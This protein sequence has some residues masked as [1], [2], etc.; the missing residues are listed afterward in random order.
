MIYHNTRERATTVNL[1]AE[2]KAF[3]P[4]IDQLRI[5]FLHSV[6]LRQCGQRLQPPSPTIR[7]PKDS[8]HLGSNTSQ[9]PSLVENPSAFAMSIKV[10][11]SASSVSFITAGPLRVHNPSASDSLDNWV[12]SH[13][14]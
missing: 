1:P 10:E 7:H 3:G 12:I 8:P 13:C 9:S 11:W 6:G 4:K 5:N 14:E 2:W